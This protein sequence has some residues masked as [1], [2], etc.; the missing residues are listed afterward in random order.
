M[1]LEEASIEQIIHEL[2]SRPLRFAF[3][4]IEGMA[5]G[6]DGWVK[7]SE[8]MTTEEAS[9]FLDKGSEYLMWLNDDWK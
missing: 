3:V 7:W 2:R 4:A 8:D 1:E 5:D 6:S 9:Y